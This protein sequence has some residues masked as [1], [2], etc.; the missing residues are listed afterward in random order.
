MLRVCAAVL[1]IVVA[2]A[3]GAAESAARSMPPLPALTDPATNVHLPGKFVWADYFTSDVEA[4][5]TFY[6]AL[7]GWQWREISAD[8]EHRYGIFYLDG[9]A[10]AGVAYRPAPDSKRRYGRWIYYVSVADVAASVRAVEARGGRTLLTPRSYTDRGQFAVVADAEAAPF[11]V[12]RSTSG[13]PLDYQ[14]GI[15][16]WFWFG[17]FATDAPGAAKFYGALFGYDVHE[18]EPEYDVLDYVLARDGYARAGIRQL[19]AD[20]Q[21][22]PSWVAY[23]RVDDVARV[24]AAANGLGA[25]TLW[26]DDPAILNGDMAVLADPLGA[27]FGVMRWTY[28]DDD[29]S[30]VQTGEA[31]P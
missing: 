13:D 20:T 29:Q 9:E 3:A 17:L 14:A 6:A 1:C 28:E 19:A 23:A 24:A 27:P 16:E 22:H 31:Q 21:S 11:G 30:A 2:S 12:M 18:P 5:R 4:A 25:T 8:P 10:V 15:G 26:G 7:F